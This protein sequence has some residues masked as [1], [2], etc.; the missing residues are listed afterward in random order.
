MK[1]DT[2]LPLADAC[3]QSGDATAALAL[4]KDSFK[5]DQLDRE[6]LGRAELWLRAEAAAGA[7]DSMGPLLEAAIE[8]Y[9]NDP[10]PFVLAAVRS[11]LQGDTEASETALIRAIELSNDPLRQV[12]RTE[13]GHL[14]ASQERFGDAAEE[15][16]KTCG[17]EASHP[18]VVA[19]LLSLFNS[20]QYL[21]ALNVARKIREVSDNTPRI[22]IE[23]EA[24][25]LGYAGDAKRVALCYGELCSREDSTPDDRVKLAAAQFR[26]GERDAALETV[27]GI[28]VSK[29]GH[30]SQALMK[31]AHI[32]R[33]LGAIDFIHDA[34][35]SRRYGLNEPDAHLGYFRLFMG[36][37]DEWEE[38][39]V[40][41]LGC[42]VR[43]RSDGE[44]QW[45]HILDDT[46]ERYGSKEL[47]AG[48]DLAQSLVGRSVGEVVVPRQG[49]G[50]LSYEITAIQSKYVRAYQETVE[51]FEIRFPGNTSLS[52]VKLDNEFT[53]IFQAID[54]RHQHV[55][56]TEELYR[57][58]RLPFSSFC[59]FIGRSMLEVWPEYIAQ[60]IT[61]LYFGTGSEQETNDSKAILRDTDG[62]VLDMMALMT[63]HRLGLA[64]HLR[65][66]FSRVAIPQQVFDEIQNVVYAMR[67]DRFPS[68]HLGKDEQG[69]Y[70]MMEI[71]EDARSERQEYF[72][73][74][75]EL[76]ETFERIPSYPMLEANEP[77]E[78]IGALTPAGA[79]AVYVGDERCTVRPVLVSDDV[80]QSLVS[81]SFGLEVVNS[82][83]ILVELRGSD[84]IKAEE[85]SHAIQQLV[86]MNYWFVRITAEDIL[87][88]LEANGYQ[89]T[90]G[91]H[92]M[93]GTLWG[94][95]CSEDAAATVGAEVIASLAKG[96]L[97]QQHL[98]LLL[99]SVVAAIRRGRH[100]SQVLL[101][102]KSEIAVRL[103]LAPLQCDQIFQAV[104]LYM[105]I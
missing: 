89:T 62:I 8:R 93:L 40:V 32:K 22:V 7:D 29:L 96:S 34:Y 27:L 73:S 65:T 26:C 101:K 15:F 103:R 70:T 60:P 54:L 42:A 37:S 51:E 91:A 13:L 59:S 1:A 4:L 76:A 33:F 52:R 72:L 24:D 39:T 75:M 83:A 81:R 77:E 63:V 17:Q 84:V 12:L 64:G 19:N 82:Q 100:T 95:D 50:S 41:G 92:A 67:V 69:R 88:S 74:V 80:V 55:R 3:L 97:G 56:N 5:L 86:L 68:S 36:R 79:G 85:Y 90:P 14:Y 98:E 35:L 44:E 9:P 58:H 99:S 61:R 78:T 48:D 31:L 38:P 105:Q 46:D 102:F 23:V 43:I 2:L 28:E 10:A 87:R 30:D 20:K 6:D 66:R 16:G 11:S 53:Q 94:P 47:S 21:K 45:W 49:F 57:S 18:N 71:P 25:I 104:D